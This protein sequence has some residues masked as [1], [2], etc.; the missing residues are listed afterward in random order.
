MAIRSELRKEAYAY[1]LNTLSKLPASTGDNYW[2]HCVSL[3][4]L[5]LLKEGKVDPSPAL[6]AL[7]KEFLNGT[8]SNEVIDSHLV[9]PF[10]NIVLK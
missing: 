2:I 4:E 9:T 6:V 8:V 3:E 1:F 5:R 10:Q 7:V